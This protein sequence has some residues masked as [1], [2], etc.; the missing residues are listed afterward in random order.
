MFLTDILFSTK[1][2]QVFFSDNV[3]SSEFS[4]VAYGTL[5]DKVNNFCHIN[6]ACV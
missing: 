3:H 6:L 5:A 2:S 4:N 1:M